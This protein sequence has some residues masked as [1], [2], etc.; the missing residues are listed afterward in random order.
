VNNRVAMNLYR[1]SQKEND[2]YDTYDSAVV[3]AESPSDARTIY[4][5]TSEGWEYRVAGGQWESSWRGGDWS[6]DR[7]ACGAWTKSP[8]SVLVEEIGIAK[9][10]TERGVIIASFNAG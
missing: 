7:L 5:G 9:E 4:P 1:L 6:A 10:G 2:G 8:A 3:A